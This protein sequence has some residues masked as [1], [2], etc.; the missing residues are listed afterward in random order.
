MDTL[1]Y[2][3]ANNNLFG[4]AADG[5]QNHLKPDGLIEITMLEVEQIGKENAEKE[6][7]KM[8]YV[9]QRLRAYPPMS[10]FADAWVKQ[11]EAALEKYRQD[12]LAV[13]ARYPKA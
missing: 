11:D 1:H 5:S 2:K 9:E 12:C 6:L 3:D 4:F 8:N 7:A 10:N 13:K